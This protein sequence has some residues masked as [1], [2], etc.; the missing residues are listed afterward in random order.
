MSAPII[1]TV[2][3]GVTEDIRGRWPRSIVQWRCPSCGMVMNDR[4]YNIDAARKKCSTKWHKAVARA[5][6]YTLDPE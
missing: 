3:E 4:I 5:R 2:K 1:D 6:T